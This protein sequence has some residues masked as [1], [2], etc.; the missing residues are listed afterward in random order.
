[1]SAITPQTEL[2]LLKCPIEKDNLNQMNFSNA[3]TQYN[4]FNSLTHLT[5]DNFTY[6]RKEGIIRYPEHI[7]NLL[8][9]NYVMYQNEAYTNKWFYAFITNMEYVNDKMTNITIKTDVFQTWQFDLI[10]KRSFVEREH[11]NNDTAGLHTI[12]EGLET[13]EYICNNRI[14]LNDDGETNIIF[15]VIYGDSFPDVNFQYGG[16]FS[17][18]CF[19]VFDIP[20]AIKFI[21]AMDEVNQRDYIT[22]IFMYKGNIK[23][24]TSYTIHSYTYGDITFKVVNPTSTAT[25]ENFTILSSKPTT[26]GTYTPRNKKLLT[27]PYCYLLA[28]NNIGGTKLYKYEDFGQDGVIFTRL[29]T[30][31]VG[32]SI[33]YAPRN[34]KWTST[35]ESDYN[36]SEGFAGAKF[37]VCS[38]E[39]DSYTNWLTQSSINR[40]FNYGRDGVGIAAGVGTLG[41]GALTGNPLLMMSGAAGLTQ[42]VSG[43]VNDI[44]D[45]IK[46]KQQ[47]QIAPMELRGNETLGD[48]MYA[49]NRSLPL[50]YK[51]NIKPEY[52]QV[53]DRFFDMYG[54]KVNNV[55]VP[56]ITGRT[57]WNYVKTININLEGDIPEADLQEIK[58]IFNNG[59]TI[60]HNPSTYLDYSQSNAIV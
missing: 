59:V 13:G 60:W 9:Y 50:F 11:V 48:V 22:S 58:N 51:M 45:T 39:S 44:V 49:Y 15:Q 31:S 40:N 18:T 53:I 25:V 16:V 17:G 24:S 43:T 35:S 38:W 1:M 54:Y 3:T 21:K 34:Y 8:G 37:P 10:Y 30:V 23:S 12:P 29:S 32:G 36:L 42:G 41:L 56:N 19:V 28:D 33:Y 52:A 6:Q 57:N 2:R 55:K 14:F 5:A 26:V 47:H 27:F 7:D 4:Y 46:E 20:N